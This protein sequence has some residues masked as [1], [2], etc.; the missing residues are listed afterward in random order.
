MFYKHEK[1]FHE[2]LKCILE[3]IWSFRIC[4]QLKKILVFE[5]NTTFVIKLFHR[6]IAS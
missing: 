1:G 3:D 6:Q 4:I 2:A 5:E